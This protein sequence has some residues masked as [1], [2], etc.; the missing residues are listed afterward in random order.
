MCGKYLSLMN[1]A[2]VGMARLA[3][4]SSVGDSPSTTL[5]LRTLAA[6]LALSKV[7]DLASP[8]SYSYL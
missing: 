1:S 3:F 2:S 5:D 6:C 7:S 4:R 8:R